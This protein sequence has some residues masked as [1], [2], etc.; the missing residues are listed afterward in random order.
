MATKTQDKRST[1]I[2]ASRAE[3]ST[4]LGNAAKNAGLIDFDPQTV[5]VSDQGDTGFE[6]TFGIDLPAGV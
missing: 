6:I 1:T 5:E 2:A 3:M 4:F